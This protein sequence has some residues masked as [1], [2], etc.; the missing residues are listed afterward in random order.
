M[1]P[2]AAEP[3][4]SGSLENL[5]SLDRETL[6]QRFERVF[7]RPV[8]ARGR[9]TLLR[10]A[11]G[12]QLQMQAQME[13]ST[14]K[15]RTG[16]KTRTPLQ[17]LQTIEKLLNTQGASKPHQPCAGTRLIRE[18]KGLTHE[19]QVLASGYR[20]Q[21]QDFQSLSAIAKAITGTAWSGPAFFGLK[22]RSPRQLEQA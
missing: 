7:E 22:S 12:W 4:D 2:E 1:K 19:V 8:P 9:A 5:A 6:S 3:H 15:S 18:W 10:L 13:L 16:V 21:N 14:A 11:L 17:H 20:Y